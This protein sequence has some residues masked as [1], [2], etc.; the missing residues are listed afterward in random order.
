MF[1]EAASKRSGNGHGSL[2]EQWRGVWSSNVLN[3]CK[4]PICLCKV[5]YSVNGCIPNTL[6]FFPTKCAIVVYAMVMYAS[7]LVAT[8]KVSDWRT[9]SHSFWM[10]IISLWK[11]YRISLLDSPSLSTSA[12]YRRVPRCLASTN[13]G[14]LNSLRLCF[15]PTRTHLAGS[16]F[17]LHAVSNTTR[18]IPLWFG[19]LVN[20]LQSEPILA[21]PKS[22]SKREP[23][24]KRVDLSVFSFWRSRIEMPFCSLNPEFQ[25]EIRL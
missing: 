14:C 23:L 5:Y 20:A 12:S 15:L 16:Q 17:S 13:S 19:R 18:V 10:L 25:V 1:V 8:S 24:G 9:V 3:I 11:Q 22:A 2:D 6:L 21:R 4:G 7:W